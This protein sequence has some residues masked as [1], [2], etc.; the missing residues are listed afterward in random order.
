M[1]Y[2]TPDTI[3]LDR[4]CR[5]IRIPNDINIL[6][7]VTG[8][9]HELCLARNW[10]EFGAVTPEEISQ[11]MLEM[12]SDLTEDN[13]CMIGAIF[14]FI[15]N[16]LPDNWLLCDGSGYLRVDYPELYAL[17]V[18]FGLVT[19]ADTFVTPDLGGKFTLPANG[20]FPVF[21]SGGE[22]VHILTVAEMP[23]HTHVVPTMGSN[24]ITIGAGAPTTVRN[25][26]GNL[27]SNSRGG[28]GAH[29]NMPPY[30]ALPY[31]IVAR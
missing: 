20:A 1:P 27:T 25:I 14:P 13:A 12:L 4:K 29:N 11:A 6:G 26:I 10:E 23:A 2:L 5:R 16:A 17:L 18:G 30:V 21:S 3:P 9:L 28:D 7:A 31:A 24:P 15:R 8:A 19:G 22:M